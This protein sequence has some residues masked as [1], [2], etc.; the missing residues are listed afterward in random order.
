MWDIVNW[1]VKRQYTHS[2]IYGIF[3]I[4][5]PGVLKECTCKI[6]DTSWTLTVC[7]DQRPDWLLGY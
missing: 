4:N 5:E 2:P 3:N 6:L 1:R 7:D